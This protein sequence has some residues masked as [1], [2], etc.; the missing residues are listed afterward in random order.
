MS[1][2]TELFK[3]NPIQFFKNRSIR[4]NI[5]NSFFYFGGSFLQFV[6]AIFT[7]PIYAKYLELEDF[8][9]MGYF[10]AIQAIIFPLFS[11]TLPF[12]YLS[13]Y[14][15]QDGESNPQENLSFIL[16]FLNIANLLL[17]I[18][19]FLLVSVYFNL[20][21][22]TFPLL[23]FIIIVMT[24]LYFEKYKLY[25]LI[26]CRVQKKGLKYFLFSVMQIFLNTGFSL[27]FVVSLNGGA[28]G[29]M[30][31][32]MLGVVITGLVALTLL[33]KEKKYIFSFRVDKT[34]IKEALKYCVPLIVGAYAY[35][36]I[37]NIDRMFLERLG[38]TKEY[39]Y[40]SIGLTI[41]GFAG[42]F[43]LALYQSFEPDLYKLISQKRYKQYVLFITLYMLILGGLSILFITFSTPVVSFLTSGRYTYAS[44]YANIFIIGIFFMQLGGLFEQ[45]FTAFGATQYAMWRNILMGISCIILYYFMIQEY[46]FYGANITR[47]IT[48]VIYVLLGAVLFLLYLKGGQNGAN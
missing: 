22:I 36:P 5:G 12:Y 30:S 3:T 48:S 33:I 29:R 47:V 2:I 16:N 46:A 24:N 9:V 7:Q 23:P 10:S 13:K 6:V 18:I 38:N 43:F 4:K 21:H 44:K 14:W 40:Y 19:S 37:T 27:Y 45:L 1:F 8:A 20:F 15:K 42:T 17:A 41:A 31:G 32:P 39:G 25:Y 28:I 11:M 34:K 35:Y 26:E